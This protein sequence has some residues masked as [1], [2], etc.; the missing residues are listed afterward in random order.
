M[1]ETGLS[2]RDQELI[3]AFI[4][5]RLSAEDRRAF[6]QRLDAEEDLYEVFVE[7]VRYRDRQSGRPAQVIDHPAG[8]RRWGRLAAVAAA[9]AAVLTPVVL[10]NLPAERYAPTLVADGLL[11][12]VL[13]EEWY[14]K[15]WPVM[16]G[17][18]PGS[19]ELDTAFRLG[20]RQVDL[21]VALRLGRGEDAAVLA[22][23]ID[24]L[25]DGL[26]MAE[27]L[28]LLYD[29]VGELAG[30]PERALARAEESDAELRTFLGDAAPAYD[31][32]QW[33]EAGVLAARS[34]NTELLGS[35][36]FRGAL[37]DLLRAERPELADEL[38]TIVGL[39]DAPQD[40]MELARLEA[41]FSAIVNRR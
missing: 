10:L 41:A 32:G 22:G 15:R 9:V 25:L 24:R 23:E 28:Q 2:P 3:A 34:G 20:V 7:T 40:R 29:E 27:V 16:R 1:T 4:D 39:L 38:R 21:E 36:R 12:P 8:G 14:L 33:T 11:G 37:R 6:M 13:D 35:R 30:E 31:L 26:A 17:P 5:R 19:D 18:G